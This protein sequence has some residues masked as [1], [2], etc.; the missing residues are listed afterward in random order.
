[1]SSTC[2]LLSMKRECNRK[3]HERPLLAPC[4][5]A[6]NH[7]NQRHSKKKATT[8][9]KE[10]KETLRWCHSASTKPRIEEENTI[11]AVFERKRNKKKSSISCFRLSS[12]M[13]SQTQINPTL[14]T[15]ERC[16]PLSNLGCKPLDQIKPLFGDLNLL[17]SGI[18]R[19]V[20]RL[21]P[22][23]NLHP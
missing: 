14:S 21:L 2:I 10:R 4:Y 12:T 16:K 3:R 23:K 1:M 17:C 11:N 7:V 20:S 8:F 19:I 13:Q 6:H 5:A 9:G 18:L 22:S 15:T